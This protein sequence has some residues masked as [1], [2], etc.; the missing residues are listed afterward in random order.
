M[1]TNRKITVNA[2]VVGI[3]NSFLLLKTKF[4]KLKEKF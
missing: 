2:M 1:K 3:E 4:E